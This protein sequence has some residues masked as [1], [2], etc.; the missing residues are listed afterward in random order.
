[1]KIMLVGYTFYVVLLNFEKKKTFLGML[2]PGTIGE[3][4][5]D[6]CGIFL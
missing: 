2:N 3:N 5:N 1:M 4:M 6:I